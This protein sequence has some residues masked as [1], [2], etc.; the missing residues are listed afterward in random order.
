MYP[1]RKL[2]LF[3][4]NYE[5]CIRII[6]CF[7]LGLYSNRLKKTTLECHRLCSRC[8]IRIKNLRNKKNSYASTQLN[9]YKHRNNVNFLMSFGK[10]NPLHQTCN[11]TPLPN[12]VHQDLIHRKKISSNNLVTFKKKHTCYL[13]KHVTFITPLHLLFGMKKNQNFT[14]L[15]LI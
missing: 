11:L 5:V 4:W 13:C 1:A 15:N 10:S 9:S 6:G 7:F 14:L 2:S 3:T 8:G 12:L